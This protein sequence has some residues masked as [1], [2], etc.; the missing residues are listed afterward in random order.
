MT[1]LKVSGS[2]MSSQ[3][4]LSWT[5]ALSEETHEVSGLFSPLLRGDGDTSRW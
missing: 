4:N 5:P 3:L 2:L 1:K